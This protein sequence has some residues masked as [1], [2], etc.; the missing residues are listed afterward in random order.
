MPTWI[1]DV[2]Q[3]NFQLMMDYVDCLDQ[4]A[5]ALIKYL[6]LGTGFVGFFLG[7][8]FCKFN[9]LEKGIFFLGILAW[10]VSVSLTLFIRTPSS[11]S[12]PPPI[13]TAFKDMCEYS[14]Q[15]AVQAKFSLYYERAAVGQMI[16]GGHKA[17]IL[18]WANG[19]LFFALVLF[20]LSFLLAWF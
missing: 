1:L 2:S 4:K 7:S 10:I 5:D 15:G 18:K 19:L 14:D 8:F 20:L 3:K 12:Y 9:S 11:V 13:T 6:G 17:N 16:V